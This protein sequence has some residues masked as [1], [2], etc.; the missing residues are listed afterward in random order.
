M[1]SS[2]YKARSA[3]LRC[4]NG[5]L[6]QSGKLHLP[7]REHTQRVKGPL[8]RLP[9]QVVPPCESPHAVKAE[10]AQGKFSPIQ[11]EGN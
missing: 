4:Y 1:H 6:K 9:L 7:G 11:T 3:T 2:E 10:P 8:P 5:I